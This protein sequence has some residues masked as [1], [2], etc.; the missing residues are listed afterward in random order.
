MENKV[1]PGPVAHVVVMDNDDPSSPG[2]KFR[3]MLSRGEAYFKL[4]L[5]VEDVTE[6]IYKLQVS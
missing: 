4:E 1:S 5:I 2:G 6:S 3:C